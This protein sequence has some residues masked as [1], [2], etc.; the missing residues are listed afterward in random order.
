ME[1][2]SPSRRCDEFVDVFF[3]ME[4]PNVMM[5]MTK[6]YKKPPFLTSFVLT[7]DDFPPTSTNGPLVLFRF[8]IVVEVPFMLAF[9][10]FKL[11]VGGGVV[12]CLSFIG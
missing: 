2:V 7:K 10:L 9:I 6:I 12:L 5:K 1:G 8:R 4:Y 11:L 3:R